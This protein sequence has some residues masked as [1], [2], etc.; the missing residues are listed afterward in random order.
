M[1]GKPPR[2]PPT[3]KRRWRL[4]IA[5]ARFHAE[6]TDAMLEDALKRAASLGADVVG[7]VEVRGAYDLPLPVRRLLERRDVDGAVAIGVI[8]KGE[9]LHDASIA[10]AS[11][12]ALTQVALEA[13]K[14]VGLGITGP[15][16]TYD[17]AKA[18]IDRAGAAVD[19]VVAQLEALRATGGGH[20]PAID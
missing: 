6:L 3:P 2:T 1:A 5:S 20:R 16:Q 14:P 10:H 4:A 18:R 19:A 15:G 12:Y 13:G 8:L 9:T 11:F 7:E 17:Q